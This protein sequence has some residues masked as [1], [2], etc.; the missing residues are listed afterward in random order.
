GMAC[1]GVPEACRCAPRALGQERVEEANLR[2]HAQAGW[3]H[4]LHRSIPAPS[5]KV[6]PQPADDT[7][8][9]V[10]ANQLSSRSNSRGRDSDILRPTT[11]LNST[12]APIVAP[13]SMRT[14][15]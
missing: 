11:R 5:A 9:S 7:Q 3:A 12:L 1:R 2:R 10:G 8:R 13:A 15:T 6:R 4:R 14:D